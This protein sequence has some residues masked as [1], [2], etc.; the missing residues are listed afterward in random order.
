MRIKSHLTTEDYTFSR[1]QEMKTIPAGSYVKILSKKYVPKEVISAYQWKIMD[2]NS[3]VF[4]YTKYGI[5][6]IPKKILREEGD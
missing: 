3:E 1:G 2:P 4:C 5:I 6:S